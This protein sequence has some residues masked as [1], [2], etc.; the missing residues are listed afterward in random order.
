ME[1][2]TS[3]LVAWSY[4]YL[5]LLTAELEGK[6]AEAVSTADTLRKFL[7]TKV[8][9]CSALEAVVTSVCVGLGVDAG[10]SGSTLWGCIEALYSRVRERL[11]DT[12]HAR[13]KKALAVVSSHY[14]GIDL[15]MV[16]EG[17]VVPDDEEEA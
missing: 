8:E 16:S 14:I 4:H 17:Y 3:C 5:Y 10:Q 15:P 1:L 6:V 7:D 13:V 2:V 12:L 11:R 9:E